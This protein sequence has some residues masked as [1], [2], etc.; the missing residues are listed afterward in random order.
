MKKI[1][2]VIP[3]FNR[4]E[5]LPE[6][7]R[8]CISQTTVCEIIVCDHGSTDDT[9]IVMEQFANDVVYI[10]REKDFG[11]HFCWLEGI[12]NATGD[13]IHL[14]FD[15]DLL[16]PTYIEETSSLINDDVGFV[17]SSACVFHEDN[18]ENILFAN[19]FDT[20][21]ISTKKAEKFVLK[22]MLSPA[23]VLVRKTDIIDALYQG[24][25][26]LQ[27]EHYHGVGPDHFI[28]LLCLLRYKFIGY[29]NKPLARFRA[30]SGSITVDA[31]NDDQKR[32]LIRNAYKEAKKYYLHLK[33][34][35][36]LNLDPIVKKLPL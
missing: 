32:L 31:Q 2:I 20:N 33:L 9:P 24:S 12:L 19:V 10:R 11:P 34:R 25:L 27:K 22:N 13:F 8:S 21:I 6:T 28:T 4:A 3:T 7:I 18:T 29:I 14:H 15:D 35:K 17:F 36:Y 1:S 16:E 23:C 26:P 30:H 5:L